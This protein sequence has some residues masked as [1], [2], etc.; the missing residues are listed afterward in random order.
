LFLSK[1]PT[2][3]LKILQIS[4]RNDQSEVVEEVKEA[5]AVAVAAEADAQQQQ[6]EE[7]SSTVYPTSIG[8]FTD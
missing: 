4:Q 8:S 2:N 7:D 1:R 5:V 3:Q 6:R